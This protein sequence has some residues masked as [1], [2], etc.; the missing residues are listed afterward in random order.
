MITCRLYGDGALLE[1]AFDPALVSEML[2]D[3]SSTRLWLDVEDPSS[4]ELAVIAEEFGLHPLAVEDTQ[5]RDQR[6]KVEVFDGNAFVVVRPVWADAQGRLVESEIHA[7][8]GPRSLVTLRYPPAF[9]LREAYRRSDGSSAMTVEGA[10]FLLYLVVDEVVDE[11]LALVDSFEDRADDLEEQIFDVDP[12]G[13]ELQK[14]LFRLRRDLVRF[15]RHVMPLRRVI[16]FF[17][18]RPELVSA[19]LMPYFRDVADHVVR[20]LEL[21]DNVRDLLTSLLEVRIAQA[22]N[23]L[24]E[25]MKKVTSWAAIILLPTLIAGIYGMNF[26]NMPELSWRVGYPFALS[27]MALTSFGLWWVFRKKDWL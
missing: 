11:Y 24:N 17:L 10:A 1:R 19:P 15:R 26:A 13:E 4:D 18:E 25:V 21:T 22:A 23:R 7:F 14:E 12:T 9:D 16:D 6:P 27:L 5:H 8:I 2:A 20:S 3:G